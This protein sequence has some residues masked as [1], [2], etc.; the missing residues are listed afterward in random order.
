MSTPQQVAADIAGLSAEAAGKAH[1]IVVRWTAALQ[2]QVQ[3]NASG[4]PGPNA[5]TGNYRRS[6]NRR[7]E[8]TPTGS[9]GEVGTNAPQ[10]LR[11][12]LGFQGEDSL[13]RSYSQPPYPHFGPALDF[14][15]AGFVHAMGKAGL[16][17]SETEGLP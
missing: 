6:I 11:L 4:R 13:G 10:A 9:I 1:K 16:P 5:P 8:Q 14:V 12:E 15:G 2:R 3:L 7:V 17:V